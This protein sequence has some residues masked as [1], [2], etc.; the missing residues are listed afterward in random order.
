M[1]SVKLIAFLFTLLLFS[2]DLFTDTVKDFLEARVDIP[3]SFS[4]SIETYILPNSQK[5]EDLSTSS[6]QPLIS[7]LNVIDLGN[8]IPRD[9]NDSMSSLISENKVLVKI[10]CT[11]NKNN[12]YMLTQTLNSPLIGRAHGELLPKSAFVC[13][14]EINPDKGLQQGSLYFSNPSSL[15]PGIPQTIYMADDAPGKNL[16]NL[17]N[18]YYWIT[19][20][21][22]EKV[23][24]SQRSDVYESS[25]TLTMIEI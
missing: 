13:Q 24:I 20:I 2:K 10:R 12:R 23:L 19:D 4:L 9:P 3:A 17:I 1:K 18:I 14:T 16:G 25:L 6:L 5:S 7:P 22:D 15:Y 8:L 11:T 21:F